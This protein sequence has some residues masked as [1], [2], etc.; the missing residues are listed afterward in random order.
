MLISSY[1]YTGSN[2]YLLSLD[3]GMVIVYNILI[4]NGWNF[5]HFSETGGN[6]CGNNPIVRADSSGE[7]FA[8]IF[9]LSS[10]LFMTIGV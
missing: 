6:D 3:D 9:I 4:I 10:Y 7:R 2:N 8:V 1:S 5:R